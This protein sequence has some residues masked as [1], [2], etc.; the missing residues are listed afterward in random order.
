MSDAIIVENLIKHFRRAHANRPGS[1]KE[2]VLRGFKNFRSTE[3]FCALDQISFRVK[4]GTMVGIIGQ[5]GAGKSTLLRLIGGVGRADS[6]RI[7]VHGRIGALLDLTAGFHPDL[8]GRENVF[9]TGVICGLTRREVA[10]RMNEIIAFA[11]LEDSI[12]NPIRTYS[13]GMQMRLG[14]AVAAH[15]DPEIL[16]IDE[17]LA[18][19][20]MAFQQKCLA[21]IKQFKE[22]GCTIL[23]ISHDLSQAEQFC[24]EIIWLRSGTIVAQ[25]TPEVIVG[26]YVAELASETRRRTPTKTPVLRTPS[27]TELRVNENRFGS[28]E[29]EISSV[30]FFDSAGLIVQKIAAGQPL[31]ISI[32]FKTSCPIQN[33]IFS[34]SIS[35][36]DGFVCFDTNTS[37]QGLK[38]PTVDQN[39]QIL[40][41]LE[42][43]DLVG[44]KYFV[45]VGIYEKDFAYG[46]DYHWHAYPLEISA[47]TGNG[48][49]RAPQLW[50][51]GDLSEKSG[52]VDKSLR[53]NFLEQLRT[54]I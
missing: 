23:L 32:E 54:K 15:T 24:D 46:Y 40:L 29:M 36:D 41:H 30:Q 2:A 47:P 20:D 18:V 13:T 7:S 5:N 35:R 33:P 37:A 50:E 21:R 28:M 11:E 3:K 38:L 9:I 39:G 44:G 52:V 31:S 17:V 48:I 12:D 27:G 4:T 43:L 8:T 42:R 22:R 10:E 1:L 49:L 16:L 34:I 53:P 26:E 45:D 51:L 25:G 6:G 14:F 19:G